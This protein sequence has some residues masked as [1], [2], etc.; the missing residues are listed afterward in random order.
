MKTIASPLSLFLCF[1]ACLYASGEQE[2][3]LYTFEQIEESTDFASLINRLRER[4]VKIESICS[5]VAELKQRYLETESK[6]SSLMHK[7]GL[8]EEI[9]APSKVYEEMNSAT[10]SD[11][12]NSADEDFIKKDDIPNASDELLADTN[13]E[14]KQQSFEESTSKSTS[15]ETTKKRKRAPT[16]A[17]PYSCNECGKC[18]STKYHLIGHVNG[19]TGEKPYKCDQC[20]FSTA[21]PQALPAHKKRQ[22]KVTSL[23]HQAG[24]FEEIT[25]PS[26]IHEAMNSATDSK[27]EN[28]AVEDFIKKDAILNS[29]DELLANAGLD[30][31]QQNFEES[32]R[33]STRAKKATKAHEHV[34]TKAKDNQCNECGKCF[35]RSYYLKVHNRIHTGETPYKCNQCDKD[36]IDS[37]SLNKHK[38]HKH[39]Q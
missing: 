38:K 28:I 3:T 7:A 20:D 11:G 26:K 29:S 21:H 6:V 27:D 18:F 31:K 16:K 19:H 35:T 2:Q 8:F 9:T 22:H 36:F 17:K 15:A 23:M 14:D 30:D 34:S 37:C 25:A 5:I 24:L 1:N 39:N 12:E 33:K 4:T 10:D 13:L 32:I